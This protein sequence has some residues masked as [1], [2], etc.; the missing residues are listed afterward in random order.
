MRIAACAGCS[1]ASPASPQLVRRSRARS[2][3]S[4]RAR[5]SAAAAT[6]TARPS[7]PPRTRCASATRAIAYVC[8]AAHL[9][10]GRRARRAARADRARRCGDASPVW[11]PDGSRIAYLHGVAPPAGAPRAAIDLYVM[12]ADGRAAARVATGLAVSPSLFYGAPFAWSPDGTKLAVS[13]ADAPPLRRSGPSA[14][15]SPARSPG[16]RATCMSSISRRDARTRL[17]RGADFDGLPVWSGSRVAYAR[18]RRNDP[19]F[20]SDVRVV[21][22]ATGTD[23]LLLRAIAHGQPAGDVAGRPR[24]RRRDGRK[25][26]PGL[27][28]LDVAS[29][30]AEVIVRRCCASGVSWA[31]DAA[32]ARGRGHRRPAALH[33]RLGGTRRCARRGGPAVPEPGLVAR[34]RVDRSA[35]A[36]IP[37]TTRRRRAPTSCSSTRRR[38][39]ARR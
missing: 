38:A 13:L 3:P 35:T 7:P 4:R 6:A 36:H 31:P 18:L 22:T 29:G 20:R 27:T 21:D 33:R 12:G 28:A 17:T 25:D 30:R 39:S 34:R 19:R 23:R 10:A 1:P 8:D 2:L 11:S 9:R 24:G 37:R 14:S 26:L 15:C 5:A 32:A 16:R